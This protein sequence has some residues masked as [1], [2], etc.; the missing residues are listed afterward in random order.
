MNEEAQ[1]KLEAVTE[2][3]DRDA[4]DIGRLNKEL[5]RREDE[6]EGIRLEL[7]DFR[8]QSSSLGYA[9]PRSSPHR[10]SEPPSYVSLAFLDRDQ[11]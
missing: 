4:E 9:T 8:N 11:S 1:E 7:D 6:I 5:A 2:D 10:S 3:A